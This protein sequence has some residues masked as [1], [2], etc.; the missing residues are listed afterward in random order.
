M[1]LITDAK[2]NATESQNRS[3]AKSEEVIELETRM[4]KQSALI[5]RLQLEVESIT[6]DCEKLV[7]DRDMAYKAKDENCKKMLTVEKVSDA[8]QREVR[9]K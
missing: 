8:L 7:V 1:S 6:K 9:E 2:R 5:F 4:Q 3:R